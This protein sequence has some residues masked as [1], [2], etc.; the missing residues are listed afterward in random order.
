MLEIKILYLNGA[1]ADDE[2]CYETEL[3]INPFYR[4]STT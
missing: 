2:C 1:Q 4:G 3:L